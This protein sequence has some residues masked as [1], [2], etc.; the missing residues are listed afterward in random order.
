MASPLCSTSL[1]WREPLAPPNRPMVGRCS[2]GPV[3]AGSPLLDKLPV[4]DQK[5]ARTWRARLKY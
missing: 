2:Q 5:K 3:I 4:S 1:D